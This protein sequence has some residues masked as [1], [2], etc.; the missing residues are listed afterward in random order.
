MDGSKVQGACYRSPGCGGSPVAYRP[1]LCAWG[2]L[3]DSYSRPLFT[4]YQPCVLAVAEM[5]VDTIL[6]GCTHGYCP[7]TLLKMTLSSD[8]GNTFPSLLLTAL[9]MN[10]QSLLSR[11]GETSYRL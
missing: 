1:R 3:T 9:A 5:F 10:L 6:Q 2:P 11:S 7:A 8:M 4:D